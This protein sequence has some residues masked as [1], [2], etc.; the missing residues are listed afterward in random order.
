MYCKESKAGIFLAFHKSPFF[1]DPPSVSRGGTPKVSKGRPESPLVA[2]A[3]AKPL[4]KQKS[5]A[6]LSLAFHRKFIFCRPPVRLKR[7]TP[8]VSKGRP[9]SPLVA[10]AEAKPLAKQKSKA[11]FCPAFHKK[12]IFC[13]PPVHLKG[14]NPEGFQR[15]IGKPFGR[16]RRGETLSETKKARRGFPLP[17]TKN[18]FFV[19]PPV[20]LK[21]WNPEG[22]QRAT[23]K[24]FGRLRRGETLSETKKQGGAFPCLPQEI[25]S[26]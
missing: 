1:V 24:P 6:G 19:D 3:E 22:F 18:L 16:L 21:G 4:A 20:P 5:K 2:S 26:L 7:W 11:G 13:R 14:W 8:K 15:A 12:F 10:S 23:G 9:E 25:S 17:S